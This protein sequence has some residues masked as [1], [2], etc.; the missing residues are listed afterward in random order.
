VCRIW[1]CHKP[2]TAAEQDY[3]CEDSTGCRDAHLAHGDTLGKC[4]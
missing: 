3:C 2:G 4:K 1:L